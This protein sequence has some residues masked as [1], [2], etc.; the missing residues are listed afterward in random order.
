MMK[1]DKYLLFVAE[2]LKNAQHNEQVEI[3]ILQSIAG[4]EKKEGADLI[5]PFLL[6]L[7]GWL[8]DL[9]PLDCDSTQWSCLR[10]AV[11][12]LRESLMMDVV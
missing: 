12:Y 9:S 2:Q 3:I 11:I 6:K 5:R 4:I 10:Y 1:T 8:E 7:Q